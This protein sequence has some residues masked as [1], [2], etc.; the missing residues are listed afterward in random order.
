L[1]LGF[2]VL[3]DLPMPS[4]VREQFARKLLMTNRGCSIGLHA[5]LYQIM[6]STVKHQ[7]SR[8][9]LYIYDQI[10]QRAYYFD[11][12]FKRRVEMLL[13]RLMLRFPT[14]VAAGYKLVKRRELSHQPG[15][16][17]YERM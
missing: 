17:R 12:N 8:S 7:D 14:A 13:G 5:L 9:A 15:Q 4:K 11:R 2:P 3:F 1:A 16:D 10:C 6:L